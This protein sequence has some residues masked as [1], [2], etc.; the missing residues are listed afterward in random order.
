MDLFD[1]FSSLRGFPSRGRDIFRQ[2]A[3]VSG[4][5]SILATGCRPSRPA[6]RTE[7]DGEVDRS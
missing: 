7:V 6:M 5:W 4:Q 3:V 1:D 2:S